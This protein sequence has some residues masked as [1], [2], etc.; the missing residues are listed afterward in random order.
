MVSIL[1][2]SKKNVQMEFVLSG[3]NSKEYELMKKITY[4]NGCLQ[5]LTPVVGINLDGNVKKPLPK[6]LI[7]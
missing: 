4:F 6:P 2:E 5:I 3:I 1:C 7:K